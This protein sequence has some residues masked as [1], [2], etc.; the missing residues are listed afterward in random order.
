MRSKVKSIVCILIGMVMVGGS[1]SGHLFNLFPHI[2]IQQEIGIFMIGIFIGT[3][4]FS[5]LKK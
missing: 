2:S 3:A 1:I 4:G 5:F